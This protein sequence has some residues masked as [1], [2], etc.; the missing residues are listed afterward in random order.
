[1]P[2]AFAMLAIAAVS[3]ISKQKMRGLRP[4]SSISFTAKSGKS[5][6]PSDWPERLIVNT[7]GRSASIAACGLSWFTASFNTQRSTAGISW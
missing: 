1:M 6:S 3:V 7:T 2:S 5:A 4:L